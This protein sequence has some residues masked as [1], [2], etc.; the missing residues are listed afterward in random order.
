MHNSV[1]F[2]L[3]VLDRQDAQIPALA[4]AALYGKGVFTT[5]AVYDSQPCLWEKHWRRLRDN[6]ITL[7]IGLSGF[8]EHT[9][10]N[11]LAELIDENNVE[12]GR[13][14][15][16]FFDE[17]GSGLWPFQSERD[18]SLLITTADFR[19]SPAAARLTTSPFRINSGS[20]L[21]GI[22]SCNYL[23]KLLVQDEARKR[24]FDECVQLNE[25]G[26]IASASMA[27]IFWLK[28]ARLLTPA[29]ATCCLP[30]TT[31]EFIL[32]NLACEEVATGIDAL[33]AADDIYLT[34]AGVGVVHVAEFDGRRLNGERHPI[35]ELLPLRI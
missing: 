31:R 32:E 4:A 19:P 11:A 15:I 6:S 34:S 14:R 33:E 10:R 8:T 30:G 20:P 23:E 29:L 18:T 12:T 9:T 22:K 16:T 35:T 3:A 7:G 1:S 17:A 28:D 26:E 2:N 27:N 24:G 5:L 13:A 21:T 25:R